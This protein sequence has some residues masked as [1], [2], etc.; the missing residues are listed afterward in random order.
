MRKIIPFI[1]Q[2]RDPKFRKF[3][4]H[5]G[6]ECLSENVNDVISTKRFSINYAGSLFGLF[7]EKAKRHIYNQKMI[8]K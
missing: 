7:K 6:S 4:A 3:Q 8:Y 5:I 2:K 1:F